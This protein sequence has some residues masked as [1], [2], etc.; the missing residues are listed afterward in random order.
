MD[1]NV[2]WLREAPA[3]DRPLLIAAFGSTQ[4][5]STGAAIIG[6]L[7]EGLNAPPVAEI[8][9]DEFYD[10]SVARPLV[11]FDESGSRVLEWPSNRFHVARVGERD[12]VLFSGLEP[13]LR[14][15]SFTRAFDAVATRLGVAKTIFL[16][17]HPAPVPHTRQLPVLLYG[18]DAELSAMLRMHTTTATYE[19]PASIQSVLSAS[20]HERGRGGSML[21]AATPFYAAVDPHPLGA[22]ALVEQL[23]VALGLEVDLRAI[24]EQGAALE[25]HLQQLMARS[26]GMRELVR[27]LEAGLDRRVAL[28][29]L[30]SNSVELIDQIS[31]FL[32]IQ[33]LGG[34]NGTAVSGPA[35]A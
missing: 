23:R 28:A 15:R 5:G 30:E 22:A 16:G 20:E 27:N 18:Q 24:R 26:E 17:T 4:T 29:P 1:R 19:G 8:D 2:R 9:P 35:E 31:D 13:H 25:A 34:S 3:L 6:L 12:L 32:R 21:F 33:R 11:Q 14:W 7:C 10:F